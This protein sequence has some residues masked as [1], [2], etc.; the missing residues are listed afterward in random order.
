MSG[1]TDEILTNSAALHSICPF[2]IKKGTNRMVR[3][4]H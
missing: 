1:S 4:L 2:S 3:A